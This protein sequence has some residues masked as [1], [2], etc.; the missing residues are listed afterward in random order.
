MNEALF[1]SLRR[2]IRVY[3]VSPRT[4]LGAWVDLWGF[5]C[6]LLFFLKATPTAYGSSQA[7]GQIGAVASGLHHSHSNAQIQSMSVTY[8]TAHS[9]TRSLTQQVKPWMEPVSSWIPVGFV[10][11]EP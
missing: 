3:T 9:N 6:F 5:F 2:E 4:W 10:T 7:S 1:I 11:T 8:T